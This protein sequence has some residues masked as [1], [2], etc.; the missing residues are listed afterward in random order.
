MENQCRERGDT[1]DNAVLFADCIASHADVLCIM[2]GQTK[3]LVGTEVVI[4]HCHIVSEGGFK[5]I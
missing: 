1:L 5:P 3:L 4:S 2:A